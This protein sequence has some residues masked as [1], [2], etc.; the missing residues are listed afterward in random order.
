MIK[1]KLTIKNEL[2]LHARASSKFS[3]L[4]SKY[5]SKISINFNDEIVDAKNMMD[6]LLLSIGIGDSFEISISGSD[7]KDALISIEALINNLFGEGK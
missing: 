6:V 7:E 3:D 5:S 2:G 4:S 1:K